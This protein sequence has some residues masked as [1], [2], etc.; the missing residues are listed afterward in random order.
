[1][2]NIDK[3]FWIDPTAQPKEKISLRPL[4]SGPIK[5]LI[6]SIW[7]R[8]IHSKNM[9]DVAYALQRENTSGTEIPDF[10]I[11]IVTSIDNIDGI[12]QAKNLNVIEF[13]FK[14]Q[15]VNLQYNSVTDIEKKVL[16]KL[17]EKDNSLRL[18]LKS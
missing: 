10:E 9:R 4:P 18:A 14:A 12:Q 13:P 16:D 17:L 7:P 1:M 5:V 6:W 2:M 8:T 11:T 15:E 3:W